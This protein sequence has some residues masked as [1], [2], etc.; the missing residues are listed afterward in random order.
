MNRLGRMGLRVPHAPLQDAPL[1]CRE[2]AI[3]PNRAEHEAPWPALS[4][5][6]RPTHNRKPPPCSRSEQRET[7]TGRYKWKLLATHAC[8]PCPNWPASPCSPSCGHGSHNRAHPLHDRPP[9]A[10]SA[11]RRSRAYRRDGDDEE[12]PPKATRAHWPP[13]MLH[14]ESN[15]S[16]SFCAWREYNNYY[17]KIHYF[18]HQFNM[19]IFIL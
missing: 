2:K 18:C 19:Y 6:R 8:R 15:R 11:A 17:Q 7:P 12:S 5:G 13:I 3:R 10:P 4:T 9:A 16:L 1:P 14:A